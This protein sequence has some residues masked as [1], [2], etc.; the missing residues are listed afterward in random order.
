MSFAQIAKHFIAYYAFTYEYMSFRMGRPKT[1]GR[2]HNKKASR[3]TGKQLLSKTKS[4]QLT[5]P[6]FL[7]KSKQQNNEEATTS[8]IATKDIA[9]EQS[10]IDNESSEEIASDICVTSNSSDDEATVKTTFTHTSYLT[11][12]KI[13]AKWEQRYDFAIYSA[14]NKG[15]FCSV[16]QNYGS[17]EYWH[18]TAV[19]LFEHPKRTLKP[20]L[21]VSNIN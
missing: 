16:C 3:Y 4:K 9:S 15:W 1:T 21:K 18:T 10:E 7:N 17:G 8:T 19:K 11:A 5:L 2:S 6:A 12:H 20:T 14:S 13:Q